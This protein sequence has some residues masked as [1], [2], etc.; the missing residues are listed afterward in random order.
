MMKNIADI[1]SRLDE[2][3]KIGKEIKDCIET[4]RPQNVSY[5]DGNILDILN[6]Q[7]ELLKYILTDMITNNK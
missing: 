1:N 7:N 3:L 2:V 4:D 6:R 5:M